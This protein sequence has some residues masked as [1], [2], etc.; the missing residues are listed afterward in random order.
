MNDVSCV[1]DDLIQKINTERARHGGAAKIYWPRWIRTEILK[2]YASGI[3]GSELEARTGISG[4]VIYKWSRKQSEKKKVAVSAGKFSELRMAAAPQA[5]L[6]VRIG[7]FDIFGFTAKTL[8]EFLRES[9][10]LV[11]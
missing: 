10:Q 2:L 4:S 1:P 11:K 8:C 5:E 6:C 9:D 7:G 3:G